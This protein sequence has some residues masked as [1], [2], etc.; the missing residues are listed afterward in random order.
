MVDD[1][2]AV[3]RYIE[4]N[5]R[6]IEVTPLGRVATRYGAYMGAY[7]ADTEML[8]SVDADDMRAS[9][10]DMNPYVLL[11][12]VVR[13]SVYKFGKVVHEFG[14]DRNTRPAKLITD[15]GKV[16]VLTRPLMD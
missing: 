1:N 10:Y 2:T 13:M 3:A 6:S 12:Q 11:N 16:R 7:K 8:I 4:V 15:D 14:L 9:M 5:I